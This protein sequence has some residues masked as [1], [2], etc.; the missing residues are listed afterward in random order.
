MAMVP[1]AL[2]LFAVA[3]LLCRRV[4][5]RTRQSLDADAGEE[6]RDE[7]RDKT[8]DKARA[9]SDAETRDK[10]SA[11]ADAEA[12]AEMNAE[13]NAEAGAEAGTEAPA[14]PNAPEEEAAALAATRA[15]GQRARDAILAEGRARR[16]AHCA[17][18]ETQL[19]IA[20]SELASNLA[21]DGPCKERRSP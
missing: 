18:A 16:A 11:E 2:P 17:A 6:P 19:R 20:V 4:G 3:V 13:M 12:R 15:E 14:A 9:E 10:A 21:A 7:I 1:V 5:P 8:R